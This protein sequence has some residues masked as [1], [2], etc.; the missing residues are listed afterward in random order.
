MNFEDLKNPEL[1]DKL[2]SVK[3]ADELIELAKEEGVEL[4]DEQVERISGGGLWNHP[5]SC[6]ACGKG[7][8]YHYGASY[9]CRDCGHEWNEGG[10]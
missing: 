8:I 1:Q 9:Y 3:T 2:K 4:T 5:S 6:P 10:W 7:T